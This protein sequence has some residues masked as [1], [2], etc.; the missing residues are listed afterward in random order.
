[1]HG[2][3]QSWLRF[4]SLSFPPQIVGGCYKHIGMM[5][6]KDWWTGGP[7]VKIKAS[8]AQDNKFN[9]HWSICKDNKLQCVFVH[10]YMTRLAV[11][12]VVTWWKHYPHLLHIPKGL[13]KL[14]LEFLIIAYITQIKLVHA[15]CGNWHAHA[16]HTHIQFR[17]QNIFHLYP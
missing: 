16:T 13:A 3:H 17:Y 10:A 9:T 8:R 14:L 5:Q 2:R 11:M 6:F 4:D 1:M 7:L 12:R 15:Q